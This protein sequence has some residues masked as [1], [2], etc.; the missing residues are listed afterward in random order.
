MSRVLSGAVAYWD[1]RMYSGSGDL[2]DLTGNGHH[3]QFGSGAG[4]DAN[5]PLY[6]TTASEAWYVYF[7]GTS[8]NSATITLTAAT[9]Y[10][11]TITYSDDTTDTDEQISDGSGVL[12]FGGTDAK[13]AGLK[14]KRILI[15]PDGGGATVADI[16]FTQRALWDTARASLTAVTGQTVTINR[17]TSGRKTTVVDR[18]QIL[19]GTDDYLLVTDH[20]QLKFTT[21][22]DFTLAMAIRQY[23]TPINTGRYVSKRTT[24]GYLL[25]SSGTSLAPRAFV[26]D[27][28]DTAQANGPA[29]TAGKATVIGGRYRAGVTIEAFTN[30][31]LGS[32]ASATS[33]GDITSTDNFVIGAEDGGGTRQDFVFFAAALWRRAL[34]DSEIVQLNREF[35]VPL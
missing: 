35:Q 19:F 26:D 3:A 9:T 17:T 12:T 25:I 34:T 2:L 27:G 29:I 11:Y 1:A 6:L 13:F 14:V 5:D 18:P 23:A 7:P 10:D 21:G 8:G 22:E 24:S 20:A 4:A 32:S 28:P 16:D 33:I 30:G 15:V 31:V